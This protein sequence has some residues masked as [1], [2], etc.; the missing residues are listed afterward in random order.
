MRL[1]K[2][3][4]RAIAL[5]EAAKDLIAAR[6]N[7]EVIINQTAELAAQCVV[8]FHGFG[9]QGAVL[10]PVIHA[11]LIQM[12]G[13]GLG[14][15]IIEAQISCREPQHLATTKQ[16]LTKA[17]SSSTERVEQGFNLG[18]PPPFPRLSRNSTCPIQ[19]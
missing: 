15:G 16:F 3:C 2:P 8:L 18:D 12:D 11:R 1:L 19:P 4:C 9:R 7:D 10:H 17:A 13:G 14:S 6:G 5:I